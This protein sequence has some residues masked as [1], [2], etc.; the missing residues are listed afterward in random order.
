MRA[1]DRKSNRHHNMLSNPDPHLLPRIPLPGDVPDFDRAACAFLD[2]GRSSP[3][4]V[5]ISADRYDLPRDRQDLDG[6]SDQ[7]TWAEF[8]ADCGFRLDSE[9]IT[10]CKWHPRRGLNC[11]DMKDALLHGRRLSTL[12]D[13]PARFFEVF[14]KVNVFEIRLDG[15]SGFVVD[16]SLQ[17]RLAVRVPGLASQLAGI[18]NAAWQRGE[19]KVRRALIA[20][21]E[22]VADL[23]VD[24]INANFLLV[25][26]SVEATPAFLHMITCEAGPRVLA[27]G[28]HDD[29][30]IP[31]N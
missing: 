29:R 14:P 9:D 7:R 3:R 30:H 6:V 25:L 28:G 27:A 19:R 20:V 8:V 16:R 23:T 15:S 22:I 1:I 10:I 13:E 4:E 5:F 21:L 26:R 18:L 12:G 17:W 24:A 11:L 31:L 2:G